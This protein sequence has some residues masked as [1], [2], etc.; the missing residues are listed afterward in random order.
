MHTTKHNRQI[1]RTGGMRDKSTGIHQM[2]LYESIRNTV[3]RVY[4]QPHANV[5][6]LQ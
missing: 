6:I 1:L 2:S 4:A 5:F 3:N